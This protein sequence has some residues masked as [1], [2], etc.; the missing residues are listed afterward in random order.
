MIDSNSDINEIRRELALLTIEHKA[1]LNS[2]KKLVTRIFGDHVEA[3][4]VL[5]EI[6]SEVLENFPEW[7]K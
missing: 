3:A 7:L 2:H 6:S 4:D 1:L 5:G